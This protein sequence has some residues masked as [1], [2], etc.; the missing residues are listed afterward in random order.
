MNMADF[1]VISRLL[2]ERSGL[3]LS[4][5]KAYLLESRLGPVARKRDFAGFEQLCQALRVGK[6]E[7]LI[8]DV[9]EALTTNESCFFRDAKPFDLFRDIV[10]P[11]ML[12]ARSSR[13]SF[14]IWGAAGSSGQEP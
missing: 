9:T 1:D 4:Q 6:D 11:H 7:E 3:V 10:L 14:R 2:K 13:K 12:Q 8:R 5:D